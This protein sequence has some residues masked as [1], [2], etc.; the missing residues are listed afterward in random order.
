[1][2]LNSPKSEPTKSY[3]KSNTENILKYIPNKSTLD[4]WLLKKSDD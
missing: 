4:K 1:M 2:N 3:E